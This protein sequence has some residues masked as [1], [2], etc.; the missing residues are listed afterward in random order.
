MAGNVITLG[1]YQG[2]ATPVTLG[3]EWHHNRLTMV[4][5]MAVWGCPSRYH[6]MWDRPRI[7]RTSFDLLARGLVRVDGL[8]TQRFSYSEAPAAYRFIDEHPAETIKVV[9]TY[10]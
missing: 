10:D 1:Y 3:D 6:P 4:S 2:G 8:I 5:S 9:L 7:T